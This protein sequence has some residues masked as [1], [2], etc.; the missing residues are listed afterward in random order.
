[1]NMHRPRD[2]S[3]YERFSAWH[4]SFYRSVE[5][6][7]VTP[8]SPRAIDRGIAGVTVSLARHGWRNLTPSAS[9]VQMRL[10][11]GRVDFVAD[12]IA[13][14]AADHNRD[15]SKSEQEE[16]RASTRGR[17][18]DLLDDWV[19]IA[20]RKNNTR[21]GL[22]YQKFEPGNDAILLRDPLSPDLDGISPEERR[23]KANRSMRDVELSV[24]LWAKTLDGHDVDAETE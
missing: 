18:A 1:M 19:K 20:D 3:H 16:L 8:F 10:E 11:R 14:R 9:A 24:N 21:A 7:S 13:A 5:A 6:T 2:R 15:L 12:A 17:V 23:F 4:A 22:R